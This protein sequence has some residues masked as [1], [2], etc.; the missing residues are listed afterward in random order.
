MQR[1]L[2]TDLDGTLLDHTSYEPGEAAI[3]VKALERRGV[4]LV[5]ASS[6]TRAEQELLART[7][8]IE[9]LLVVENGGAVVERDRITRLGIPRNEIREALHHAARE[10]GTVV[11]GYGDVPPEQ[12]AEWTGLEGS[13]LQRALQREW[14]ETFVLVDGDPTDL[15]EH[16]R[17]AGV[18]ISRGGRFW[19]AHGSHDKGT[20]VEM[21]L[22]AHPDSESAG[23]GDAPNDASMLCVVDHPFQVRNVRGEWA[24]MDVPGLTRV[25]GVGPAGFVEAVGLLGW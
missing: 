23:I 20:A 2:V 13:A 9:P 16:I 11:L 24:A 4:K 19:T 21:I 1:I 7:L 17:P 10:T 18:R 6:K 12:V 5:F 15:A 8:D 22:A 3:V 14:S 25:E